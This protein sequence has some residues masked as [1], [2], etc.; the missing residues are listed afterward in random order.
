MSEFGHTTVTLSSANSYSYEKV[1]MSFR[2]YCDDHTGPQSIKTLGNETFYMFGDN[3]YEEWADFLQE[4][5]PPPYNLP[6]HSPAL[7]FGVAGPGS[8]VPFH[9]HG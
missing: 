4:Y 8:G 9:T 3:D 2:Q 7:S 6:N 1:K 5:S